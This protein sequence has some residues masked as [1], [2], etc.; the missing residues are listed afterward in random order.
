MNLLRFDL[1]RSDVKEKD[2]DTGDSYLGLASSHIAA[3]IE[4]A[5]ACWM[6]RA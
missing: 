3:W 5:C 4:A 2:I 6:I 1:F